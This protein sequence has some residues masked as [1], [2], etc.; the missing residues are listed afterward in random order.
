MTIGKRRKGKTPPEQEPAA[1]AVPVEE[2]APEEAA[3]EEAP[4]ETD[5][6]AEEREA[7]DRERA[8]LEAERAEFN[9]LRMESAVEEL[10]RRRDLPI[11]FAPWLAAETPEESEARVEEFALR[12]QEAVASAVTARLRGKG[13]PRE[14]EQPGGYSRE[15]LRNLSR[16]EINAH[17]EEIQRTLEH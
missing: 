15:E 12:F 3:P 16:R 10:L 8:A 11:Q 1:E 14:P 17:W 13:A 7:L 2:T 5:P 4:A 6:L 9:R